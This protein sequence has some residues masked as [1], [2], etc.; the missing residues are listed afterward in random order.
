MSN[1]DNTPCTH[2]F[3]SVGEPGWSDVV[4]AM[5]GERRCEPDCKSDRC[6][7]KKRQARPVPIALEKAVRQ[8]AEEND[9]LR[10][11]LADEKRR[12]DENYYEVESLRAE[13]SRN[14]DA[15]QDDVRA[16]LKAAGLFD[17]AQ[18]R[19]PRQCV[20]LVIEVIERNHA[21]LEKAEE[22]VKAQRLAF[23]DAIEDWDERF[24]ELGEKLRQHSNAK[25]D[26][27]AK[28]A[29]ATEAL[30]RL[31][32]ENDPLSGMSHGT[33]ARAALAAIREVGS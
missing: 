2:D 24:D 1:H 16:L 13:L 27:E 29:K 19:S 6:P 28:L 21:A 26:A 18:D 23:Y 30:R 22:L 7:A 20:G 10:T 32:D 3:K 9:Q 4:C 17:G 5:C 12:A 14:L 11:A 8:L 31:A 15:F 33:F 25:I